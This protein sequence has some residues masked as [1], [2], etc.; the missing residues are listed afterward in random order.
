LL[1]GLGPGPFPPVRQDWRFLRAAGAAG[2]IV[3][4]QGGRADRRRQVT[5]GSSC[6]PQALQAMAIRVRAMSDFFMDF[7]FFD[8]GAGCHRWPYDRGALLP[9]K[10]GFMMQCIRNS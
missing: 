4:I 6:L 7:P 10:R 3:G 8:G 1:P 2:G 9:G 5:A